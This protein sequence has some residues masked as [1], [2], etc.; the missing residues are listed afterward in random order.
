[1]NICWVVELEGFQGA[2]DLAKF[3]VN[4]NSKAHCEFPGESIGR[5]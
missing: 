1:M 2:I 3:G 5:K 4:M